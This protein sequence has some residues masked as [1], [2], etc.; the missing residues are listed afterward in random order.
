MRSP[1]HGRPLFILSSLVFVLSA[2]TED[3]EAAAPEIVRPVKTVV[4]PKTET[5]GVRSFPARVESTRRAEVSF[6]VPGTIQELPIKEGE[7]LEKGQVIAKLDE[8]DYK[9]SVDDREAEYFRTKKDFE[10]AKPLAKKGFV[11]KK[12]SDR[13]EAEMKRSLAALN[14]ARKD[15]EYTV[16]K[17][18]FSGEISNRLVQNFEEVQAKQPIIELRDISALEV[19]FNV[20]EQIMVRVTEEGERSG[21]ASKEP[22]VFAY[23]DVAPEKKLKL[24]FREISTKADPAT[25]TFEATY[26][27]PVPDDLTILPGMT[28]NVSI[29]LTDYLNSEP[30][31]FLPVEAITSTNELS[32]RA[33]I[34]DE[35]TMTVAPRDVTVGNL[36]GGAIAIREGLKPGERVV[37][38]G[39]PFLV[40][41]MK[42]RLM[43]AKEQAAERED[44]AK[45]R[46]AAEKG[47]VSSIGGLN[48][49]Q[50][51]PA[52]EVESATQ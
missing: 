46:R 8:T 29:D 21:E 42:V 50:Q 9:L 2:C 11:T 31:V 47:V 26:S 52:P 6:R 35:K 30:V 39:V 36:R 23:F 44:D 28:T 1:N 4:I 16:L 5:S 18:P 25:R 3:N 33:W 15:L 34:V 37:V 24:T 10:R 22:D 27:L 32:G 7:R 40:E 38:A 13:R 14:K 12:E 19:K 17:A 20:P 43:P 41:G 51:Q 49:D 48:K 45:I